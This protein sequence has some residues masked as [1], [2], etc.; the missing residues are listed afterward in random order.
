MKLKHSSTK[1]LFL[2]RSSTFQAFQEQA[3]LP[4]ALEEGAFNRL[5][6][7]EQR[8][9]TFEILL[10]SQNARSPE[11]LLRIEKLVL[12]FE[13]FQGLK[14][15]MKSHHFEELLREIKFEQFQPGEKIIQQGAVADKM[16]GMVEVRL[17]CRRAKSSFW[18]PRPLPSTWRWTATTRRP[19]ERTCSRRC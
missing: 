16:Y 9:Q 5:P 19:T 18:W 15:N 14:R 10:K 17:M 6:L 8:K 3:V 4:S 1:N 13:Y 11:D 2:K 12:N 7:E